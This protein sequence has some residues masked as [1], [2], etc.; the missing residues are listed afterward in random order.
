MSS[1]S[2]SAVGRNPMAL[3]LNIFEA[4][5][6]CQYSLLSNRIADNLV[7]SF[8]AL[9]HQTL[10][11]YIEKIKKNRFLDAGASLGLSF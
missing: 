5:N 1:A 11:Q 2:S 4:Q 8:K 6:I 3:E 10:S 7:I 9:Q